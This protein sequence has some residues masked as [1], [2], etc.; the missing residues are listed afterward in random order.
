MGSPELHVTDP[1][2]QH[3][4]VM[5]RV[6]PEGL[7]QFADRVPITT[8]RPRPGMRDRQEVVIAARVGPDLIRQ[9]LSDFRLFVV[10]EALIEIGLRGRAR[11][12]L[13]GLR[14]WRASAS[15]GRASARR[16]SRGSAVASRT[17]APA[18]RRSNSRRSSARASRSAGE[19]GPSRDAPAPNVPRRRRR[20]PGSVRKR[21]LLRRRWA[22]SPT[23]ALTNPCDWSTPRSWACFRSRWASAQALVRY[24]QTGL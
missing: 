10:P 4:P 21:S 8:G 7:A 12:A 11:A 19:V 3:R 13:D 1:A 16:S 17:L 24:G 14:P 15:S 18:S 9:A 2:L 5:S 22:S 20:G 23:I 6:E